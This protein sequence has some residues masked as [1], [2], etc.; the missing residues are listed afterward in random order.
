MFLNVGLIC[1]ACVLWNKVHLKWTVFGD[2]RCH[3]LH[4]K[5]GGDH[6]VCDQLSDQKPASQK[7]LD[8]LERAVH[9]SG[10]EAVLKGTYRF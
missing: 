9:T 8:P 7:T 4:T 5:E 10:K 2:N 3:F 6:L 1:Q